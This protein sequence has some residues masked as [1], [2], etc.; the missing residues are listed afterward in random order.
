M[1]LRGEKWD[2]WG[3]KGG[4]QKGT[5]TVGWGVEWNRKGEQLWWLDGG[6]SGVWWDEKVGLLGRER[7][8]NGKGK[9][10][11]WEGKGGLMEWELV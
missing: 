4:F 11:F 3:G 1:G 5:S 9:G 10:R 6:L 7:G 2:R 8:C